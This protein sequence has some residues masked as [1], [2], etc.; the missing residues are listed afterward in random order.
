MTTISSSS[1]NIQYY[2]QS[3]VAQYVTTTG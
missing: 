3:T 1:S 2:V